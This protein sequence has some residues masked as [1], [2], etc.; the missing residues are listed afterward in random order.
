MPGKDKGTLIDRAK[1]VIRS[2]FKA[3]AKAIVRASLPERAPIIKKKKKKDAAK[4][5]N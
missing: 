3:A 1:K 2:P 5:N 4:A